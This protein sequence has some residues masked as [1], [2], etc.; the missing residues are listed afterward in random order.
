MYQIDKK[1]T[2]LYVGKILTN[3]RQSIRKIHKYF[4]P[5]HTLGIT[6]DGDPF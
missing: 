2:V 4:P 3:G 5:M 1:V 6:Y